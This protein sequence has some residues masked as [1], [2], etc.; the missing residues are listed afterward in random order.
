MIEKSH[1]ITS[2][3]ARCWNART[4]LCEASEENQSAK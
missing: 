2:R 1:K 3:D 4:E